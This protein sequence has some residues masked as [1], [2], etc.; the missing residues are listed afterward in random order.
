MSSEVKLKVCARCGFFEKQFA[1]QN[2]HINGNH[3]DDRPENEI[4][5]CS[6]CHEGLH[7]GKWDGSEIGI[8]NPT[9]KPY[10]RK[11]VTPNDIKKIEEDIEKIKHDNVQDILKIKQGI[12]EVANGKQPNIIVNSLYEKYKKA[13]HDFQNLNTNQFIEDDI[14]QLEYLTEFGP[15]NESELSIEEKEC[16]ERINQYDAIIVNGSRVPEYDQLSSLH[17]RIKNAYHKWYLRGFKNNFTTIN[18]SEN[19]IIEN[20]KVDWSG[21]TIYNTSLFRKLTSI[22]LLNSCKC[23]DERNKIIYKEFCKISDDGF[24]GYNIQEYT[25]NYFPATGLTGKISHI[26][27]IEHGDNKGIYF[28][29]TGNYYY[30][31]FRNHSFCVKPDEAYTDPIK[32]YTCPKCNTSQFLMPYQSCCYK[33]WDFID[34]KCPRCKQDL[35]KDGI[36]YRNNKWYVNCNNCNYTTEGPATGFIEWDKP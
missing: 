10:Q 12:N 32:N 17:Y 15:T 33:C 1:I 35:C 31:Y 8:T 36:F 30:G 20:E 24:Y 34:N 9:K 21:R 11:R 29:F 23:E 22:C 6:E 3:Y 28:Y 19:Q 7:H 27:L 13:W 14:K 26:E 5:I 16:L 2:H 18:L 4:W 25:I